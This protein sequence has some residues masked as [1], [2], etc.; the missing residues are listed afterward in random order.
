MGTEIKTNVRQLWMKCPY[1]WGI[2][3][4]I[5]IITEEGTRLI[6]MEDGFSSTEGVF[7][8]PVLIYDLEE[9]TNNIDLERK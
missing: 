6:L 1:E 9:Y 2:E 5:T 3:E 8:N 4:N 7:C